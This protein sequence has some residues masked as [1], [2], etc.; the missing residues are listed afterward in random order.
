MSKDQKTTMAGITSAAGGLLVGAGVL[1]TLAGQMG[2]ELE[3]GEKMV[4]FWT[5]AVGVLGSA[6]GK[7]WMGVAAK[8]K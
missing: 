1:L 5:V 4:I 6:I 8:D 7:L 3:R 2:L